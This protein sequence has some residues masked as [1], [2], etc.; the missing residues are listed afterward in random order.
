VETDARTV[1]FDAKGERLLAATRNGAFAWHELRS[2]ARKETS[3]SEET[4]YSS[5]A[6]TPDLRRVVSGCAVPMS[7]LKLR[8]AE[9]GDVL[10]SGLA[11]AGV[12]ELAVDA[13]ARYVVLRD[14]AGFFRYFDTKKASD[15][16]TPIGAEGGG[17]GRCLLVR[18]TTAFLGY[19]DATAEKERVECWD[20]ATG[21]RRWIA[22]VPR[23]N[24]NAIACSPD[25]TVLAVAA[26][27][28]LIL[29]LDPATGKTLDRLDIGLDSTCDVGNAVAFIDNRTFVVGTNRGILLT[30]ELTGARSGP[31]A[32]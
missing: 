16:G 4:P 29:E 21:R 26:Q 28:G 20:L 13:S 11:S 25:G 9:T 18:G 10:W 17:T 8:D 23:N 6:F 22:P 31:A 5:A 3:L 12:E 27:F 15:A 19:G 2:G 1:A 14:P 24:V 30:F 32:K 7:T